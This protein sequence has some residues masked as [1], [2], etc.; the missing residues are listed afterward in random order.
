LT[1]DNALFK[2]AATVTCNQIKQDDKL[3]A[4]APLCHIAGMVMGVNL[5]VY[6]GN[7]TVLLSRFDAETVVSAIED[8]RISMWYSIAPMNGAILQMP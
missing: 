6:S 1:Y 5:P 3:L 4:I 7:E 8:H 2:T